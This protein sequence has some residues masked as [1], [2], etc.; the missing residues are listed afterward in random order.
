MIPMIYFSPDEVGHQTLLFRTPMSNLGTYSGP[1]SQK[2]CPAPG[3][4]LR[5][6]ALMS[7][8]FQT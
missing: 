2:V 6:G 5:A 7:E 4:D 8:S 1:T 3:L